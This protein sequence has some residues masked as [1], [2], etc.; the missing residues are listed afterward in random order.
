MNEMT[1]TGGDTLITAEWLKKNT[2]IG[3]W[4]AF[5]MVVLLLSG[6]RSL[7]NAG[8]ALNVAESYG[9][10]ILALTDVVFALVLVVVGAWAFASFLRRSPAAVFWAKFYLILVIG[11]NVLTLAFA[12]NELSYKEFGQAIGGTFWSSVW[13]VFLFVSKKVEE[14]IP[15]RYRRVGLWNWLMAALFV[16][17]PLAWIVC[18][19]V[20]M[21]VGYHGNVEIRQS[22]LAEGELTD[23]H[24]VFSRLDDWSFNFETNMGFV[25]CNVT[26]V[27]GF[28]FTLVSTLDSDDSK[29]NFEASIDSAREEE[30]EKMSHKVFSDESTTV[31]GHTCYYRVVEYETE[32]SQ[33]FYW[34]YALVFDAKTG[35][36]VILNGYLPH[37]DDKV[38][39]NVIN[40]LRFHQ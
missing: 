29:A 16:L 13:L 5:F 19:M 14:V 25:V 22:D 34:H 12:G 6:L 30:F 26:N 18:G 37:H 23:G 27:D 31:N 2:S 21:L 33:W 4:L 10:G 1:E 32:N 39:W 38:M 11:S 15:K 35:K 7:A 3:G 20:D 40:S 9:S 24:V 28:A 36:V 17:I 8:A